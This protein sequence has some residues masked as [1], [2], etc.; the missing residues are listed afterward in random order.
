MLFHIAEQ[1][2]QGK[3]ACEVNIWIE[4]EGD[5]LNNIIIKYKINSYLDIRLELIN[6][7]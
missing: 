7:F 4:E 2:I 6:I 1:N 5:I 3:H